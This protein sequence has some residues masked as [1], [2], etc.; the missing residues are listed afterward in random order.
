MEKQLLNINGTATAENYPYGRL[1]TQAFFSVEFDSKKGFRSVFQTINPKTGRVNAPKK[2][3]Y[4][5]GLTYQYINPENGHI[6]TGGLDFYHTEKLA[7]TAQQL[8]MILPAI[9]ATPEMTQYLAG[10]AYNSLVIS[11]MYA[12]RETERSD[13]LKAHFKPLITLLHDM[14]TTGANRW[15]EIDHATYNAPSAVAKQLNAAIA[16]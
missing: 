1:R 6:Q 15:S 9:Q 3:T 10:C 2:S 8:A 11:I 4:S 14:M 12:M 7:A 5:R 16:A 13:E